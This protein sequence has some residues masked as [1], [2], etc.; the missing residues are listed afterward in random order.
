MSTANA[1]EWLTSRGFK[2]GAGGP[3]DFRVAFNVSHMQAT[4][5]GGTNFN[6]GS[7]AAAAARGLAPNQGAADPALTEKYYRSALSGDQATM[8]ADE[9]SSQDLSVYDSQAVVTDTLNT[10]ELS[11]GDQDIIKTL[12]DGNKDLDAAITAG[13]DPTKTNEEQLQALNSIDKEIANLGGTNSQENKNQVA[14]LEG[15]KGTVQR[16][17]GAPEGGDAVQQ[18]QT[19]MGSFMDA[20]GGVMSIAQDIIG[21][22]KTGI[23][24]IGLVKQSMDILVRG[25]E[26]TE[27]INV[28]IDTIQK[29]IEMAA[30][31]A[32]TVS[33]ITGFIG[34]FSG[35]MDF[36]ATAA[37]SAIAGMISGILTTVNAAIDMA[38]EAW[39]LFGSYFGQFLGFLAGAGDQIEGDTRFLLDQ[40]DKTLK[41]YGRNTPQDKAS[42]PYGQEVG[43]FLSNDRNQQQPQIGSIT[44]FGGPNQDPRDTTRNMMFAVKTATMGSTYAQ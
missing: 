22:M 39:H 4:L 38:Q 5:P 6:W 40:N 36:G 18:A 43:G 32:Q 23:E 29:F 42:H 33:D 12:R 26:N 31:V 13:E 10:K 24:T 44:V 7:D 37:A 11:N 17:E 25:I 34:G 15:L 27:Q 19:A 8:Y 1:A 35:K 41:A 28:F 9:V 21:L 3:G 14:A 2:K 30:K 16:P 20:A